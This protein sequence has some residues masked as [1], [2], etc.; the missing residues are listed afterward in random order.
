VGLDKGQINIC[1]EPCNGADCLRALLGNVC[2]LEPALDFVSLLFHYERFDPFACASLIDR[3]QA[4]GLV[5][6][7][8][9]SAIADGLPE[10][11]VPPAMA[12]VE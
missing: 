8:G 12:R 10:S 2:R 1:D 9:C 11:Q 4:H 7:F 6:G 3:T 5:L